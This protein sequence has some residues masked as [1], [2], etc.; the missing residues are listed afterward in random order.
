MAS[1]SHIDIGGLEE[2]L[3]AEVDG[4]IRFDSGSRAAYSTD[5]SNYRVVPIGVVV[6]RT[7]DAAADAIR[8]CRQFDVPV[9]SRG[10]G[11]TLSG[12]TTNAAVVID[13][14]KYCNRLI[15]VDVEARTCV[16]EPGILL[17]DLNAQLAE[18][19]LQFG[20]QPGSHGQCSLGGM[21]GNNSCGATAQKYGKTADN[22]RR[23]EIVTYDGMRCWV[24]P[25]T[26]DELAE[27]V[28]EGGRRGEVY[29]QLVELRDRCADE[30]R[31]QFPDIPRRVSGYNLDWLL[32]E[33]GFDVA[34]MLVGSEGSLV[35]VLR[36]ELDLVP[37]PEARALVV[38]GFPDIVEA[39]SAVPEV[40]EH[41]DPVMLEG[42]SGEL[43][44]LMRPQHMYLD[45]LSLFPDG[46]GWLMVQVGAATP[47]EANAELDRLMSGLGKSPDDPDV[48]VARERS[49]MAKILMAR[50]AGFGAAYRPPGMSEG[51]NGWEDSA[52]PP[53]RLGEYLS[54]L[55]DL[56][57]R[58]G[59]ERPALFGH[60]GHGCVHTLSP[61]RLRTPSGLRQMREFMFAAA[62][63]VAHYGGSVSG[64]H[65]DGRARSEL[66]E[67]MFGKDIVRAFTELKAIF[68]PF[69]RMNPGI[70]V[71]PDR[72]D[73][74]I[75]IGPDFR[76]AHPQSS[77]QFPDDQGDFTTAVSRCV[78]IG[79]CRTSTGGVMCPSYMVTGEEEHSTRGRSRLLFEMMQG[80]DDSAIDDGW[81]SEAVKDA[82]DLCLSCKG[83]KSDC[84]VSVDMAT[85]KA[86]FLSH[87]YAGRLR[88]AAHYSMG[89]LP[90]LSR[91][92]QIAPQL[93]NTA[94]RT[95]GLADVAKRLGGIAPERKAP[96]FARQSFQDWW[97]HR[98]VTEP[99][100]G[101]PGAVVLWPDSFTNYFQ[102]Q[103]AQAAVLLLEDA[104]FRVA[105]PTRPV[106]CGLTW[107]STGQL[108]TAQRMLRRSLDVLQPWIEA[109]TPVIGLEPSCTAV[110]RSDA[111][112]LFPNDE[113][114]QRLQNLTMTLSEALT[115]QVPLPGW[116]PP[117]VDRSAVVQTHCHQHAIMGFGADE[118]L[119]RRAGIDAD[120]LDSG[121]C[122]LAGNF[123]FE[124]GHYD[125]SMACAERV[126]FPA[127]RAA[128]QD[129]LV[130][131]DGF[132]CRTQ[133]TQGL[134]DREPRHL[135]EV[136]AAALRPRD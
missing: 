128:P 12:Q 27:I 7:V 31:R 100:P 78:G 89:W 102:P 25:T 49:E 15:S 83:C 52:V 69:Q 32:P 129:T 103:V 80:H 73:E 114:V 91:L 124:K 62:D 51:W 63:L 42:F 82:L 87:H 43:T 106:C 20:P 96:E 19:E 136:L 33:H 44:D 39:A 121:C 101:Q 13:W 108:K 60:F 117:Q 105:V 40:L 79:R 90:V 67:H 74:H 61:F 71:S 130:L 84:P 116:T 48:A 18:H 57:E 110:F 50:E 109:E 98:R 26:D 127:L 38:F 68:D 111:R 46:Y 24:G 4:E 120:V 85:Y 9:L 28:Q 53:D 11:T 59:Y 35:A 107:I 104:G 21:I 54:D 14:T 88:P 8:V 132:S 75:R 22:V 86:E 55:F 5:A 113:Q 65:G 134:T 122:G 10:G 76:P 133:I 37:V 30:V 16:V 118:E 34:R 72:V 97:R 66:L 112:D 93:A 47:D 81:R 58:V 23:L 77:F 135:A 94:M 6:P 70:I 99:V 56:Y 131:A 115:K 1:T 64:E 45:N 17:D 36:A 29:R 92:V 41:C 2:R 95:R 3:R 125:V 123:G 126:L 119:M